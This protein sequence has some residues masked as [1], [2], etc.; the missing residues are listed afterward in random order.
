[1]AA[2]SG[3]LYSRDVLAQTSSLTPSNAGLSLN[4]P[5]VFPSRT[6]RHSS[7]KTTASNPYSMLNPSYLP[8]I[9]NVILSAQSGECRVVSQLARPLLRPYRHAFFSIFEPLYRF[10]LIIY[11][12]SLFA[13]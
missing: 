6:R 5:A 8:H 13:F 11:V 2:E 10:D 3:R 7:W 12:S 1:M 4:P 9:D